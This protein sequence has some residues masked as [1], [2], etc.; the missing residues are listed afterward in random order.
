MPSELRCTSSSIAS[1]SR[2]SA[3]SKEGRLFSG[4]SRGAPRCPMR[5]TRGL[6]AEAERPV[7]E[8]DEGLPSGRSVIALY[9][10]GRARRA[11]AVR[12]PLTRDDQWRLP[13]ER[14]I[15]A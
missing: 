1:A 15:D 10:H 9:I 4:N 2:A 7:D 14:M 12:K 5:S 11:E 13:A 6:G 8:W 3:R